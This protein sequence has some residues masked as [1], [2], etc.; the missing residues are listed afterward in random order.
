MDWPLR[1]GSGG[2][3]WMPGVVGG[4]G[5]GWCGCGAEG[6]CWMFEVLFFIK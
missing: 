5:D 1:G 4:G 6:G 3:F 2:T